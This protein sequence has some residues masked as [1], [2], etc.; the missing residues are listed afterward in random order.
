MEYRVYHITS[1]QLGILGDVTHDASLKV[2][3]CMTCAR[4]AGFSSGGFGVP[5]RRLVS[6]T[7]SIKEIAVAD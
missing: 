5:E 1:Y 7:V 4:F 2:K 6:L 3:N